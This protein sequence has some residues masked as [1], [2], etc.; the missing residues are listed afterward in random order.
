MLVFFFLLAGCILASN[1]EINKSRA[2]ES[3]N[4][5]T[6]A[7]FLVPIPPQ[8]LPQ[9]LLDEKNAEGHWLHIWHHLVGFWPESHCLLYCLSR[10][11]TLIYLIYIDTI[12]N[13]ETE[14]GIKLN[15][16]ML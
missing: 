1:T 11:H 13:S 10:K 4:D 12:T 3:N 15:F 6:S 5:N 2:D 16:T 8:G 7:Y 14:K 9:H